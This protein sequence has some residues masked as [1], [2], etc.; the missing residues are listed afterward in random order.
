MK[1]ITHFFTYCFISLSLVSTAQV[2]LAHHKKTEFDALR[3]W[4]ADGSKPSHKF[5]R[6]ISPKGDCIQYAKGFVFLSWFKGG[7]QERNLMVSR[8]NPSTR[9]WVTV[10]FPDK[11]TL[12][13]SGEYEGGG[14]SHK[15]TSIG[16]SA[17]DGTVHLAYDM[18]G[19]TLQ[20]RVSKKNVAFA[21]DAEFTLDNFLAKRNYLKRGDNVSGITYP[22]FEVNDRG[23]LM[24]EYRKGTT[25]QGDKFLIVYDGQWS[26]ATRVMQGDNE[27]PEYNQYGGFKYFFGKLYM[28]CAVRIKGSD[29]E[30]NQGFFFGEAGQ[31][32]TDQKWE[33]VDGEQLRIPIKGMNQMNKFKIA[34]PLPNGH[35]GMTSSPEFVVS[36][37]GAVHFTNLI[38]GRGIVHYYI[39]PNSTEVIK[40]SGSSPEV[41]FGADDGRVYSVSLKN[42]N[43]VIQSTKEG[44]SNWRTDYRF[45]N[46]IDFD[47]MVYEYNNGKIYIIASEKKNSD[48]L[49]MHYIELD[50]KGLGNDDGNNKPVAS[51]EKPTLDAL[52]EGYDLLEVLVTASDPDGDA[53]STELFIDGVA[54][55]KEGSAPY[56]WGKEGSN[57]QNETTGLLVGSHLLEVVVTDDKGASTKISKTITVNE[58][59]GPYSGSPLVIP[60]TLEAEDYDRGGLNKAYFDSDATNKGAGE[61]NYRTT[62]GVDIGNGNG[63]KVIGWTSTGE[64]LEYSVLVEEIGKYEI[65]LMV[66]SSKG[67]GK[68]DLASNG[69]SIMKLDIPS[70]DDWDTYTTMREELNLVEGEQI[71]RLTFEQSGFNVDKIVF[72][73]MV[74]TS[75]NGLENEK[76]LIVFPNPS[77]SGVFHLN[78][79][80]DYEIHSV[81]GQ[82]VMSSKGDEINLSNYPDGTYFIH[83]E[84]HVIKIVK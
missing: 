8:Y 78:E 41:S 15:T 79:V 33:T 25:R 60:G 19:G 45:N 32:G 12:Y 16:V 80:I 9:K 66:S 48:R 84:G 59:R 43:L 30:F 62:E 36:K 31:N 68:L 58:K 49:P 74:T 11:N 67:G 50:V 2:E 47:Q 81:Q 14:N 24:L 71:L 13:R 10:K 63:G 17:L 77:K 51:F 22:N 26:S 3:F 52:E 53:I 40:A 75:T 18:H 57:Y 69:N 55:R 73:K 65:E 61:S 29:T 27:N 64:W 44:E 23:E 21:P 4:Y 39:K 76:S 28:G 5:N 42:D 56:E 35:R 54:I 38:S 34:S 46:N 6:N 72:N 83:S 1:R 7:M 82:E 20:Y 70:T 37:N